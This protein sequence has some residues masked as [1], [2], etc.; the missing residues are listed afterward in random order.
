[1]PLDQ[2]GGDDVGDNC[3]IDGIVRSAKPL[4]NDS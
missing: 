1:M 3:S 4:A 2:A